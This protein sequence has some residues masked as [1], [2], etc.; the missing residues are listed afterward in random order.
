MDSC[1]EDM[2][3]AS[4]GDWTL[5]AQCRIYDLLAM[6]KDDACDKD[7]VALKAAAFL[8]LHESCAMDLEKAYDGKALLG[9]QKALLAPLER[10]C[11]DAR[12][13][14]AAAASLHEFARQTYETWETAGI[15]MKRRALKALRERAGFRLESHR[16]G[17]Y[18]AKTFDLM[19]EAQVRFARTQQSLFSS[20]VSYKI[21]PGLHQKVADALNLISMPSSH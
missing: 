1:M 14:A 16:I 9:R 11:T 2:R 18:V 4:A 7:A 10:A 3:K 15:F 8:E 17:N 13:E 12:F 19:N 6:L 5:E 20:D 21:Q